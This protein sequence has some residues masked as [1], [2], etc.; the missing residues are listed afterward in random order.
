[1]QG[2]FFANC[3]KIF[4]TIPF[5][6]NKILSQIH[7][8]L[9]WRICKNHF[10]ILGAYHSNSTSSAPNH[11]VY[12]RDVSNL[13]IIWQMFNFAIDDL[14][15]KPYIPHKSLHQW[16]CCKC[17]EWYHRQSYFWPPS[18]CRLLEAKNTPWRSKIA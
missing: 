8:F 7:Y 3:T 1:M 12:W 16:I 14:A 9:L 4:L 13:I 18:S 2:L 15:M 5:P 6:T 10:Q 17:L 11:Q